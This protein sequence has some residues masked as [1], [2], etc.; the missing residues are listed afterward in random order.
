MISCSFENGSAA[1]LRHVCV[2][3][4]VVK[5]NQ[6]LLGKRATFKGKKILEAGKWGLIG[7]FFE[8]DEYLEDALRREVMEESGWEIDHLRLLRI[9][10]NPMRPMEDR[11]N[12]DM[13]FIT[14]AKKKKGS[15]DE[16][17][18]NL[19]W[20]RIDELPPKEMIAFDHWEHLFLYQ[21]YLKNPFP[22][23]TWGSIDRYISGYAS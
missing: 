16:E 7:G 5:D 21:K 8:R 14:E 19:R 22:L 23:P 6:V 1:Q 12:V 13:I 15:P 18:S 9:N 11:Q 2:N 3:A 10:D 4:I 20:F 17:I